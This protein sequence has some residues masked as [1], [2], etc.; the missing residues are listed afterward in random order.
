MMKITFQF[1]NGVRRFRA[2]VVKAVSCGDAHS[3]VAVVASAALHI[4]ASVAKGTVPSTRK[5]TV[6]T[7]GCQVSARLAAVTT[8]PYL[9]TPRPDVVH[10]SPVSLARCASV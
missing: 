10:P 2:P 9:Q 7:A 8:V 3:A 6:V 4:W 5:K 1:K